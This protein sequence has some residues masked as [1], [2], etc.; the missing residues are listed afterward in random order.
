MNILHQVLGFSASKGLIP[1]NPCDTIELPQSQR[2][3]AN[4]YTATQINAFFAAIKDEPLYPLY[5]ITFMYGLRRSEVLGLKWDSIDLDTGTLTIRR[6]VV[7]VIKKVEKDKTKNQTSYR[8]FP[9]S[10]DIKQLLLDLKAQQERDRKV[11]GKSYFQT[12]YVFRWPDG[13]PYAPDYVTRKFSQLLKRHG[14]PHIRL[15]DLRHSSASNLLGMGYG[16]K[17][18]QEWLGHADIKMTANIYGHLDIQR[19]LALAD[20]MSELLNKKKTG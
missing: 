10:P 14:F 16:L 15:H 3:K 4:F 18:V 7:S 12:D 1:K 6:T 2:Y 20:S 19:K 17:D 8:S 11:C 13:H 9:L 5:R